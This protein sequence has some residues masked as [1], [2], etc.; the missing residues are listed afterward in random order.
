[1]LLSQP[2]T[3]K[4][5]KRITAKDAKDAKETLWIDEDCGFV[6]EQ[7]VHALLP[8]SLISLAS[9]AVNGFVRIPCV[10]ATVKGAKEIARRA[11]THRSHTKASR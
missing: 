8:A 2:V 10:Y 1:V 6:R 9:L 3:A 11:R 4:D 5:T 7:R